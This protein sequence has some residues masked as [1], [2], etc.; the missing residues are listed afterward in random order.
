MAMVTPDWESTP[1]MLTMTGTAAPEGALEGIERLIYKRPGTLKGGGE[2]AL[3]NGGRDAA[4]SGTHD[5]AGSD[6]RGC[7]R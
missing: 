4:N 2:T 1:P 3:M 5:R 7:A 6:D